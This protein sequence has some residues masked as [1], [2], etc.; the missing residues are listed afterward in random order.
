MDT[1]NN[2]ERLVD[3]IGTIDEDWAQKLLVEDSE[4]R[5]NRIKMG[6][7]LLLP[8]LVLALFVGF[9]EYDTYS[10]L[11]INH[12]GILTLIIT[13]GIIIYY[14][15][16][17]K[18][19]G[20][21]I[22]LSSVFYMIA[23]FLLALATFLS[24]D[25][26]IALIDKYAIVAFTINLFI[27]SLVD[28]SK[29]GIL[30]YIK[31]WFR[32]LFGGLIMLE[33]PFKDFSA[34]KEVSFKQHDKSNF[35][36]V[37]SGLAISVPLLVVIISLLCSADAVFADIFGSII[38]EFR[39]GNLI[40][41]LF[42]F[43][44]IYWMVYAALRYLMS[45][46]FDKGTASIKKHS[47]ITAITVA[48]LISI[49]YGAFSMVQLVYLFGKH[50]LPN[51]YT[52]ASYAKEGVFQLM[53]LSILNLIIVLCGIAFF[54]KS[55]ILKVLLTFI[56]VCTYLMIGS[57]SYRL[58]QY[59]NICH[60]LTRKRI[61]G[62]WGLVTVSIC[63]LGVLI[64]IYKDSFKLHRFGMVTIVTTYLLLAFF[65]PDY[66]VAR[67]NLDVLPSVIASECDTELLE[68]LGLDAYPVMKEHDSEW[69]ERRG[70]FEYP[71][72]IAEY[73]GDKSWKYINVSEMKARSLY[74]K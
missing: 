10:F 11:G 37:L 17:I 21:K 23:M 53:W 2:T 62:I 74:Y 35:L 20:K 4:P 46:K 15:S 12:C 64:F 39:F 24:D 71:R 50:A 70:F 54:E 28:D 31:N 65:K 68:R 6:K 8:T 59:V 66:L 14:V 38:P 57:S 63:F 61:W 58:W 52:Y 69:L 41:F 5:E 60:G 27:T 49:V 44:Y 1:N 55:N 72:N 32:A 26:Q 22:K 48:I 25:G 33:A 16:V 3:E 7:V 56:S 47:A 42:I 73:N 29:W 30:D 67:V 36:K 13:I 19:M 51:G 45:P 43:S 40:S 18:L 9:L 34:V